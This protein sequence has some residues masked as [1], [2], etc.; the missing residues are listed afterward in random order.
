MNKVSEVL[1]VLV[2]FGLGCLFGS[3]MEVQGRGL[4]GKSIEKCAAL[5]NPKGR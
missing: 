4:N 3:Y 5:I 1:L 2:I